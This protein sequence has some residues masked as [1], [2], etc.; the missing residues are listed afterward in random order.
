MIGFK[1]AIIKNSIFHNEFQ[2]HEPEFDYLKSLEIEEKINCIKWCRGNGNGLHLLSSNDKTIRLWNV[3][4]GECMMTLEGHT[5]EVKSVAFSYDSTN[6][7]SGSIDETVRVWNVESGNCEV[8]L[9]GHAHSIYSVAFSND[10][11]K[12]KTKHTILVKRK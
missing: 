3:A 6:I 7:V 8:T 5:N 10:G 4:S 12:I 9:G 2:S 1:L 11:R